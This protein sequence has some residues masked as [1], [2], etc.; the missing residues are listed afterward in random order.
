[1][2][3]DGRGTCFATRILIHKNE[4]SQEHVEEELRT[5]AGCVRTIFLDAP[6]R[7]DRV[8]HV[9]TLLYF[10]GPESA[11]L[12]RAYRAAHG[13]CSATSPECEWSRRS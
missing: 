12:I 5:K 11:I 10:A 13:R 2:I 9:D 4:R 6:Q 1:M 3:S 7:L 8:Q